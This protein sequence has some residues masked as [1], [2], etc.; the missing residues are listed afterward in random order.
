MFPD[1]NQWG[2]PGNKAKIR[3][4]AQFG[5]SIANRGKKTDYV[6]LLAVMLLLYSYMKLF[7]YLAI[8]IT[9]IQNITNKK[10]VWGNQNMNTY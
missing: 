8:L 4:L 5:H 6:R 10:D 7:G 2:Q 1:F 9:K 3:M